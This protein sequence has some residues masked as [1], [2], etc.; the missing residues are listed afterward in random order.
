MTTTAD[1]LSRAEIETALTYQC[2]HAKRQPHVLGVTQP[3]NW[4]IAHSRIDSLLDEWQ[5]AGLEDAA[6]G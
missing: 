2:G 1:V 5:C 4:D 6:A 3:S